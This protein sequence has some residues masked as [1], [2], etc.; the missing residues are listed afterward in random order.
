MHTF[1]MHIFI[2]ESGSFQN[3]D[4]NFKDSQEDFGIQIADFIAHDTALKYTRGN[5][6][7][8]TLFQGHIKSEING[9]AVL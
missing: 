9:A 7:W 3:H 8:Y 6:H 2:D 5:I 1:S 4:P